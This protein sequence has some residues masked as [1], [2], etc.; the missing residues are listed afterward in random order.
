MG[1]MVPGEGI[2]DHTMASVCPVTEFT[3]HPPMMRRPST[4]VIDCAEDNVK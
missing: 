2:C 1:A 3:A 4:A